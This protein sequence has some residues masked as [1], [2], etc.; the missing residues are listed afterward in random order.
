MKV[1]LYSVLCIASNSIIIIACKSMAHQQEGSNQSL[2][3]GSCPTILSRAE[4]GARPPTEQSNHLPDL[5][6]M[7]FVHHSAMVECEDRETCSQAVRDIQDYH[8]DE[9]KWW[10]IGYRY[11]TVARLYSLLKPR[12]I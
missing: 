4:W 3:P 9:N 5:L 8:M 7:V 10:D 2:L 11:S 6:P 1:V 12:S